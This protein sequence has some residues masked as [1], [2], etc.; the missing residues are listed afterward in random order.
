MR[1]NLEKEVKI[2]V[3]HSLLLYMHC[4][5]AVTTA[6][7]GRGEIISHNSIVKKRVPNLWP[8]IEATAF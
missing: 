1:R 6:M 5:N 4:T 8:K 7:W 3:L 2:V